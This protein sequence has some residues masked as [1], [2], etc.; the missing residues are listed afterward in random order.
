MAERTEQEQLREQV[1]Q[2]IELGQR[3]QLVELLASSRPTDIA[4]VIE[5]LDNAAGEAVFGMLEQAAAGEVLD[6]VDEATRIELVGQLDGDEL[7]GIVATLPPDEAADVLA[8]LSDEQTEEVFDSMEP[9]QSRQLE[10]LLHYAEDSA[11]GIMNPE[12][13]TV[14]D[15]A[16]IGQALEAVRKADPE[17]DFFY[18]FVVDE[19]GTY[20]GAVGMRT[21]LRCEPGKAVA[22]VLEEE[23]PAVNVE[24]DQEEVANEFRKHNLMVMPVVD[25]DGVLVGRITFDDVAEVMDQEAEEDALVMAGTHPAELDRNQAFRAAGIRLPWLMTCL[26]GS[27]VSALVISFFGTRFSAEQWVSVFMFVPA[28]AAMGGNSGL[29]T[30]TIVVRGLGGGHLAG[31]DLGQVFRREGRVAVIV[32]VVCGLLAGLL[33][34]LVQHLRAGESG[35]AVAGSILA[36]SVGLAMFCGIMLATSLGMVLPFVFR[37]VG[38][39]P[40]IS[41]GPLVT[42]IND[43]LS[44][45]SYFTVSLVLL[46]LFGG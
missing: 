12:M 45:A 35:A 34:G 27:M 20:Q 17:E 38:I 39:D 9:A 11:G 7:G 10:V 13:I 40:A 41:C 36:V 29:Q 21:L 32:A 14:A 3:D 42:T 37:R 19:A 5:V 33:A 1:D 24:A 22:E 18:V 16:T 23:L 25:A 46:G 31:F 2:L 6:K 43:V 26:I 44:Y 4:E 15:G 30:T 28:I 8:D